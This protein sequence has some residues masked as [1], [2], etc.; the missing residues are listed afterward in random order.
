MLYVC[1]NY[2]GLVFI[3]DGGTT[4]EDM[5]KKGSQKK[6]EASPALRDRVVIKRSENNIR[7]VLRRIDKNS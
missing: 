1:R 5:K 3:D 6:Q 4:I 2:C 7:K